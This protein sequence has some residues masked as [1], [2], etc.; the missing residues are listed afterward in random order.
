[1]LLSRKF[2]WALAAIAPLAIAAVSL[3]WTGNQTPQTNYGS[4]SDTLPRKKNSKEEKI[5]SAKEDIEYH[6]QQLQKAMKDME[7]QLEKKDWEKVEKEV[8]E[9]IEKI[10]IEK[11]KAELDEAMKNLDAQKIKLQIEAEM[12]NVNLE[13]I[14]KE[15]EAAMKEVKN[16][17]EYRK[18]IEEAQKEA[19]KEAKRG[20]ELNRLKGREKRL[21]PEKIITFIII[22]ANH[23]Q[24]LSG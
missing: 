21:L 3:A 11:M 18:E 17:T 24:R 20:L 9:S 4:P 12:K 10:D 7:A 13:K 23:I 6:M 14:S 22:K 15:M 16:K 8:K 5:K 1:M 19:L 2:K